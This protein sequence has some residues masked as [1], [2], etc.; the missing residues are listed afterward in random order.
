MNILK[1]IQEKDDEFKKQNPEKNDDM[2]KIRTE[3]APVVKDAILAEQKRL[4]EKDWYLKGNVLKSNYLDKSTS[5]SNSFFQIKFK[6]KGKLKTKT[7]SYKIG[8]NTIKSNDRF[9]NPNDYFPRSD[10]II[11]DH[12]D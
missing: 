6:Q 9:N 1:W 5:S 12:Y 8:I 7:N 3:M 4:K 10:K 11:F 2:L